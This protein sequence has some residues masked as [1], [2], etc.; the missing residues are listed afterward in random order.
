MGGFRPFA[1][2][3]NGKDIMPLRRVANNEKHATALEA[4]IREEG[5]SLHAQDGSVIG[6]LPVGET[7]RIEFFRVAHG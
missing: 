6:T 3:R 7:D 5:I 2:L 1:I 4:C